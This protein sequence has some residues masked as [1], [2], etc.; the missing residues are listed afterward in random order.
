MRGEVT[1]KVLSILENAIYNIADFN[2][3]FLNTS[4]ADHRAL[5]KWKPK[6]RETISGN[7]LEHR[8]QS[9]RMY[10]LLDR[11]CADG[12]IKKEE[13]NDKILLRITST[14]RA[15][16]DA[17][18]KQQAIAL[19]DFDYHAESNSEVVIISYDIPEPEKR[20]REWLRSVLK[21]NGFQMM[22]KS[23]WIGKIKMPPKFVKDLEN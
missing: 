17:S 16:L 15:K 13:L 18:K 22:H 12:L 3:V 14:G 1:L 2:A 21:I 11:L 20:K 10:S 5:Q 19:P 23:I 7:I 8:R 4:K 9:K 6:Q